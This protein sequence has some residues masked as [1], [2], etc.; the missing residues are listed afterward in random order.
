MY[1]PVKEGSDEMKVIWGILTTE[2]AKDFN[3]PPILLEFNEQLAA[4]RGRPP[5]RG[6]G[7]SSKLHTSEYSFTNNHFKT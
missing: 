4:A 6:R 1:V 5:I 7:I 2:S 3:V